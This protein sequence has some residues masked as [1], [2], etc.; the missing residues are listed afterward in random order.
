MYE[1]DKGPAKW[2]YLE[3]NRWATLIRVYPAALL[4]LISP[5]LFATELM[6]LPVSA[7]GGW[8]PQKLAAWGDVIRAFPRLMSE[9]REIQA[10]AQIGAGEFA[11]ALTPSLASRYL[12]RPGG[13]R[14]LGALLSAYWRVVLLLVGGRSA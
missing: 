9:R 10:T 8:L 13:S 4:A 3:R 12:G 11:K 6:L 14:F 1:F 2:R 5:V 7:I